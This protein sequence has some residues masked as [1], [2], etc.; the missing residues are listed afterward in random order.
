MAGRVKKRSSKSS[1]RAALA[2]AIDELGYEVMPC[3]FC[4]SRGLRCK[5]IERS[6]RCGECVRRGRSCDGSGVPV[7]SLSRIVDESKRL[8]REEQ[9]AKESFRLERAA[10]L[11]AQQCMDESLARLDRIR[12]QKRLLLTKGRDMVRRGLASLDEVEE[13][14]RQESAASVEAQVNGAFGVV[15]WNAVFETVP[16]LPFPDELVLPL[17]A[18]DPCVQDFFYVPLFF[19]IFCLDVVREPCVFRC[20]FE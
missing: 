7:S 9:D 15:G 16:E 11:E 13:A 8:D 20:W 18:L 5:M 1:Q 12:R 2:A 14:E 3:S 6:S 4:H 17:P 10:L 19:F